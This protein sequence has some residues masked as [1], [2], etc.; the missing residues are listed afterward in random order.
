M[1]ASNKIMTYLFSR[2]TKIFALW[3]IGFSIF[4]I[5]LPKPSEN[6][7]TSSDA[8][9][10]LTGD[11]NR[12]GMGV[13]LYELG[14]AKKLLISGVYPESKVIDI[15]QPYVSTNIN[16]AGIEL[17]EKATNTDQNAIESTKW[18]R[19]NNYRSAILVTSDYHMPRALIHFK[20]QMPELSITPFAVISS[21]NHWLS[22]SQTI[23]RMIRAY[24]KFI[25]TLPLKFISA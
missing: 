19:Q 6:I 21:E 24:H 1:G 10:V 16:I 14:I 12:V 3:L 2:M 17:D 22:D 8:I 9:I 18:L 25:V 13:K 23:G 20:R 5:I 4:L 15:I 11:K 7:P